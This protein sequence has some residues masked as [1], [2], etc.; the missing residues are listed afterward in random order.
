MSEFGN[1]YRGY[2]MSNNA[3]AAYESGEKPLSKWTKGEILETIERLIR[4][5]EV[6]MSVSVEDL[7]KLKAVQLKDVTLRRSSWHHTSMM[8]NHTDF[9]EIDLE[10]IEQLTAEDLANAS[11]THLTATQKTEPAADVWECA[12]LEWSGS[13]KHPKATRAVETGII[14]GGWFYRADGSKKSVDARGFEKIRKVQ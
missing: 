11:Q 4:A 13:R 9:Y 8:F 12:F 6:T 14:K 1:G 5:G 3:I 2:S 10:R 7:A